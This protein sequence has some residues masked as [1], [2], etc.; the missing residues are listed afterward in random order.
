MVIIALLLKL[1][2]SSLRLL[3]YYGDYINII[4]V[5]MVIIIIIIVIIIMVIIVMLLLLSWLLL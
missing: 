2:I 4:I 5:I 3:S 1:W